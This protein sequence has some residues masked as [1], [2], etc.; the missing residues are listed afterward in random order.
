MLINIII[1]LF[2]NVNYD[3][4][5]I[6]AQNKRPRTADRSGQDISDLIRHIPGDI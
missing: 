1:P 3:Y 4:I 2:D 5:R 6:F